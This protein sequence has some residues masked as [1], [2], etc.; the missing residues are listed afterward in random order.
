MSRPIIELLLKHKGGLTLVRMARELRLSPRD[1]I[2][3]KDRLKKLESRGRV[4]RLRK[5]YFAVAQSKFIRGTYL[6]SRRGYGFVAPEDKQ[7]EDIFI[8]AKYSGTAQRGDMVEAF[9]KTG[10]KGRLEGRILRIL[11]RKRS[12]LL[13][14][15]HKHNQREWMTSL[16]SS[17]QEEILL[18]AQKQGDIKPGVIIRVQ[19]ESLLIEHIYGHPDDQGVDTDVIIDQY[20]LMRAF[21]DDVLAEAGGILSGLPAAVEE[22]R[23][24]FRSWKTF[25]IDGQDARDFDDAVSIQKMSNGRYRLGVH[26]AD[27]A[28]YVKPDTAVDREAYQ[29]ATSVYFPDRVLPMLPERLSNEICSL[30]P[31]EEKLAL[32][33]ILE[34]SPDGRRIA[35]DFFPSII[36]TDLRL[37]YD[38]VLKILEGGTPERNKYDSAVPDLLLMGKLA[39]ILRKARKNGGSL[40]FDLGEPGLIYE[41]GKLARVVLLEQNEAHR[42]IEEFMVAANEA[43]AEYLSTRGYLLIFRVHPPPSPEKTA[44]LRKKLSAFGLILPAG[45]QASS[46]DLQKLLEKSEG[47]IFH[48][49]VSKQVLRSLELAVYSDQNIGHFGLAK[50]T[51]THFTSPIRRY[52]DLLVHRI[53]KKALRDE[54]PQ[55]VLLA[56][57]AAHCSERERKADE[58]E[59]DL[60][61]WKIHRFLKAKLGDVLGG[62]IVEFIKPGL[63][64]ELEDYGVDGIV[65]FRGLGGDYFYQ[66]SGHLLVG[67]RTGK[68]FHLGQKVEVVLASVDPAARRIG[69]EIA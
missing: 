12:F 45:K 60:L 17:F 51:Y 37:T 67:K 26:I 40:D 3:L 46:M 41:N 34:F 4:I 11:K 1:R 42:I 58:A 43:V 64:I 23:N 55:R 57:A 50:N 48:K 21:P 14:I 44:S 29:R 52:P 35:A 68:T 53:L 13:G 25:T 59:R 19:R 22:G 16:D 15:Y 36:T 47:R 33:V 56:S 8:P 10:R 63:V 28:H 38:T 5:K 2:K 30:R 20:G 32:S 65:P 39:Q 24:D 69:L 9:V 62:I 6:P 54:P 31:G 61:D 49:Y 18:P 66:K 7:L 27:V